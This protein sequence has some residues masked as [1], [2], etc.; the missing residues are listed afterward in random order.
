M[1]SREDLELEAAEHQL[2]GFGLITELLL[3]IRELLL[4]ERHERR[5]AVN[6]LANAQ[7][8]R[9]IVIPDHRNRK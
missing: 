9:G 5:E 8:A 2:Q 1:R 3:D 6:R 7:R 4:L